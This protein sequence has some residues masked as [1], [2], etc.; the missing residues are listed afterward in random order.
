MKYVIAFLIIF[1]SITVDAKKKVSIDFISLEKDYENLIHDDKYKNLALE[2]KISAKKG[3]E[4]LINGEVRK[5]EQPQVV[6]V[7]RQKIAYA[8]LMSEFEWL[9]LQIESEKQKSQSL[10]FEI[11]QTETEIARHEA[12]VARMMLIAQQEEAERAKARAHYAELV[13]EDRLN[14]VELSK[15]EANAAKRY[16]KAQAEQAE[17]AKQEAE[18]ALEEAVSLREKLESLKSQKTEVGEMMTLGDFVFDSGKAS[19]KQQAID[20]FSKVMDFVAQFPENTIRIEGHTDSSGSN[21]LNLKLSQL[22]ANAVKQ[23]MIENGI[24]ESRIESIGMGESKPVAENTT[25]EGK[26][27]NR[28]VE[29]IIQ[30]K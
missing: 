13:A 30:P 5:K 21:E 20:N 11:S 27:K 19:I 22:R 10:L 29:I 23:L 6:Y 15:Q 14:Q 9:Q 8:R 26:A 2:A 3:I 24:A 12:D 1:F 4:S 17:L 7:T 28:R 16:A 18:L 25:S